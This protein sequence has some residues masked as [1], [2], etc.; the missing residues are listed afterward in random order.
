MFNGNSEINRFN[1]TGKVYLERQHICIK[2]DIAEAV[3]GAE[4][5][6]CLAF[7]KDNVLMIAPIS[8][9]EFKSLYR[10]EQQMLKSKNMAGD[11][12]IA[13]HGFLADNERDVADRDLS[14]EA[15]DARRILTVKI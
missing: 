13:V 5:A 12:A 3:F 4:E 11:K 7:P 6:V 10:A 2:R 9:R 14:F 1:A 15:D 8:N